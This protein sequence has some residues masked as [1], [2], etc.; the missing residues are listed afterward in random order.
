MEILILMNC[1]R[2]IAAICSLLGVTLLIATAGAAQTAEEYEVKAAFIYNFTK[3]V[4]W[5]TSAESPS[6][7]ICILG[8]D[9]FQSSIDRLTA[10]KMVGNRPV[11]VRRLKEGIEGRHCQIVFV[12]ASERAKASRLVEAVRGTS[13]LTVG[14]SVEFLRLGGMFYLSMAD[15]HVNVVIN[16]SATEAARLKVSAKLMTLAKVYKP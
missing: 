6:F 11:Q 14:E 3:F 13:V 2:R 12:G 8:D 5:P 15:N 16:S 10:G 1:R 7:A 4:E 9:P